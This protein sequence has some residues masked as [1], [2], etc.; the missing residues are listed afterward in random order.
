MFIKILQEVAE[1]Q[2]PKAKG[3]KKKEEVSNVL[4]NILARKTKIIENGIV[5]NL[6]FIVKYF[7]LIICA[8]C[9][10]CKGG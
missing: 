4:Y 9:S 1:E 5:I 3:I 7:F 6:S 10:V 2:K 8:I